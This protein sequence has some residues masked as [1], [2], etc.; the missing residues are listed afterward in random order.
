MK[1][2]VQ[3]SIA[4]AILFSVGFIVAGLVSYLVLHQHARD[5][6]LAKVDLMMSA[7]SAMRS[8]T[9]QE[10]RPNLQITSKQ[11]HFLPQSVPAYAAMSTL[12]RL[13]EKYL[14]YT[15]R[16]AALNPTNPADKAKDW[17]ADLIKQFA[18][19]DKLEQI[20]GERQGKTGKV[21]FIA[22]PIK[23]T[24]EACLSCHS[25]PDI[26]PPALLKK[27]GPINGFGWKLNE[28]VAAQIGTVPMSLSINRAN[29]AFATFMG[30]LALVFAAVF[31][32]L[33]LM[34]SRLIVRPITKLSEDADRIS[35]GD[36]DVEEFPES[37][38]SEVGKLGL[39]FNRMRRSLQE[40]MRMIG[41]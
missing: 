39:S 24:N 17:E 6:V 9:V 2:R 25:D 26:A 13:P 34:L 40:A 16:E 22:S 27:Y 5:V 15:Y 35:T 8:Y 1:L 7:A 11:G 18:S 28:V 31:V 36:F 3:F 29:E 14:D 19:N 12:G 37:E 4:L 30:L 38:K 21:L 32:V 33:N 41:V 23:I 20:V 10:V